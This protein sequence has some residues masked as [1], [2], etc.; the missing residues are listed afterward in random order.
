MNTIGVARDTCAVG[1]TDERHS[2]VDGLANLAAF[3]GRS[4]A[5]VLRHHTQACAP[6][7]DEAA[8]AA[9]TVA[10]DQG[11]PEAQVSLSGLFREGRGAEQNV[12]PAYFWARLAER[13]LPPGRWRELANVQAKQAARLMS[14]AHV[15]D[16]EAFVDSIIVER[17]KPMR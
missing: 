10:A 14:V 4:T 6:P 17:S 8:F 5:V 15:K 13:R 16:T 3:F 1:E 9:Y 2:S 7:N 12:Y 11:D